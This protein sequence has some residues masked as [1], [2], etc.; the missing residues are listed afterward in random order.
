MLVELAE[1]HGLRVRVLEI[2]ETGWDFRVGHA[3]DADG[4]R[5]VLRAPRRRD[6]SELI[7]G[8]RRLLEHVR[9]RLAVAVPDWEVCTPE[10]IA[11][12]RL[13]GRP[14]GPEYPTTLEYQWWRDP[15]EDFFDD[16]GAVIAELHR[17]R[18]DDAVRL[19]IP[20]SGPRDL[21]EETAEHLELAENMLEVPEKKAARWRT[22][23]HDDDYWSG[24]SDL[25]LVH[26]DLHPGHTLVDESGHLTGILDWTDAAVDD[27]A[28]DFVA[29]HHAFGERGL[30]RLLVG[31]AQA[32][33]R[34]RAEFVSHV[35]LLSEFRFTVSLGVY[36]LEAGRGGFLDIAQR[37]L[38]G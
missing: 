28:L 31:Y 25:R 33:G 18:V 15:A 26:A 16:L 20:V 10:L 7:E 11:Y 29:A 35:R 19:G 36:A 27:P 22:W 3:V 24:A 12:R 13:P 6:V 14:L 17:T 21:R 2:D 37:R 32:G 5:W 30:S 8:E 4:A 9:P 34:V 38:L 23:I 1:R